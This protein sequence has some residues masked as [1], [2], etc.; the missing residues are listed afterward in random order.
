MS[1]RKKKMKEELARLGERIEVLRDQENSNSSD[2]EDTAIAESKMKIL[3]P[4]V[5][6][7]SN[8]IKGGPLT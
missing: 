5:T 6:L 3:P 7:K 2:S 8:R 4:P 1:Q